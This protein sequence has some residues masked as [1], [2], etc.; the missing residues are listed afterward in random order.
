MRAMCWESVS[1]IAC[2]VLPPS[3]VLNTPLPEYELRA[4]AL[5]PVPTQT[6]FG[7][8]WATASAPMDS[9][10]ALSNTGSQVTPPL[11]VFHTPPLRS[12]IQ[13]VYW[14]ACAGLSGTAMLVSQEPSR[15]GPMFRMGSALS[16]AS[17][18][19]AAFEAATCR[20]RAA[21]AIPATAATAATIAHCRHLA[22]RMPRILPRTVGARLKNSAAAPEY[23][24]CEM[25][26]S[27]HNS[28]VIH[29]RPANHLTR[30]RLRSDSCALPPLPRSPPR[31]RGR[32]P[33]PWR[34]P[35]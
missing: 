18:A 34:G 9:T 1:P 23:I 13:M 19:E 12:P 10:P 20:G 14:C 3:V 8:L 27:Y 6:M 35:R 17:S 24:V 2:Q 11:V 32:S 4:L 30:V 21:T 16:T 25:S 33:C 7:S 5:S 22:S 31:R 26:H 15:N 29:R 28:V